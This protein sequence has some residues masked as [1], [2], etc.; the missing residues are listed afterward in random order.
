[1]SQADLA[2]KSGITAR[3]IG[4]LERGEAWPR[5][6][7]RRRIAEALGWTPDSLDSIASGGGP[8][9]AAEGGQ[10][11]GGGYSFYYTDGHT[12]R[13]LLSSS[14]TGLAAAREPMR[15]IDSLPPSVKTIVYAHAQEALPELVETLNEENL[16]RL[17]AFAFELLDN[18]EVPTTPTVETWAGTAEL[19]SRRQ[20]PGH[21]N[22][23]D[24]PVDPA[25]DDLPRVANTRR[26]EPEEGDDDYG[27][28]A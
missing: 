21:S 9:L 5:V 22:T 23:S 8:E 2:H 11:Q 16:Q 20:E 17:L 3:T 26:L 4:S 18:Q 19:P 1:M 28:G 10:V 6:S 13:P 12:R 7:T 24:A 27:S 15:L 14:S 25:W